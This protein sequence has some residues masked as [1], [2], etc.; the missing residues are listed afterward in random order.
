[1]FFLVISVVGLFGSVV[2]V[3]EVLENFCGG[4]DFYLDLNEIKSNGVVCDN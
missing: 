1:M 2:V 4:F 3:V